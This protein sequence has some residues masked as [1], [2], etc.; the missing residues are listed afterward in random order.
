MTI[1]ERLAAILRVVHTDPAQRGL[2]KD[3]TENLFTQSASDFARIC[4]DLASH[5]KP[6]VA[7]VTG[8]YIPTGT[9]PAPETDGPLGTVFLARAFRA[10]G[11]GAVPLVDVATEKA[12]DVGLDHCGFV[13]PRPHS[14]HCLTFP[15]PSHPWHVFVELDWRSIVLTYG[16]THLLSIEHVG[17][18]HK[19]GRCY[20]MRGRDLTEETAPAHHFFDAIP[21]HSPRVKTI[22]IGDGGNEIGMGKLRWSMI[23]RNIPR[24]EQIA[25]RVATDELI[26]AG[27]SNWGAYALAAGLFALRGT[28]PPTNLFDP[29]FEKQLLETMVRDG[30]LVDGVT[31]QQTATV[32]G[33]DWPTYSAPLTQLRELIS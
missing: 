16:V 27:V 10:L 17:P 28:A 15:G 33:L 3:P 29:E 32:D 1:D 4:S 13:R 25:C 19:D 26:V 7:I 14:G 9:P 5:A 22:G 6:V 21:W 23:A 2:A 30:P 18:S 24:G 11:I 31:G 12:I 8:F 20:S